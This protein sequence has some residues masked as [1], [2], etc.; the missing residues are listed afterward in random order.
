MPTGNSRST[1]P[2]PFSSGIGRSIQRHEEILRRRDQGHDVAMREER[3]RSLVEEPSS[4]W[5][6]TGPDPT[7]TLDALM[8]AQQS[9]DRVQ[10]RTRSEPR[11]PETVRVLHRDTLRFQCEGD[12]SLLAE[13]E[14]CYNILRDLPAPQDRTPEQID[15]LIIALTEEVATVTDNL[16]PDSLEVMERGYSTDAV[17]F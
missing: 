13:V 1:T 2:S 8:R 10:L 6:T 12:S 5:V 7:A 11:D 4:P 16:T 17:P 14:R 15:E 3:L 9:L